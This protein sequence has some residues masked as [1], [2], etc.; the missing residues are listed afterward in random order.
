VTWSIGLTHLSVELL[1]WHQM[2]TLAAAL[3]NR[4]DMTGR[5]VVEL[6]HHATETFDSPTLFR[7]P[8]I[9]IYQNT[10]MCHR[11]SVLDYFQQRP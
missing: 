11:L 10:I 8:I 4:R 7:P 5:E 2:R 9:H 6:L 3:F 1:R